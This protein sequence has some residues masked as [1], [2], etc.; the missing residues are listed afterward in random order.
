[1]KE[2]RTKSTKV[3]QSI[4]YTLRAIKFRSLSASNAYQHVKHSHMPN[5][6][7]VGLY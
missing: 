4:G 7:L 2:N 3:V 1:M 6:G 5:R